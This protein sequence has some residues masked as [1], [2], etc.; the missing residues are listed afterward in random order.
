MN[1]YITTKATLNIINKKY[2]KNIL[3]ETI[4]KIPK[5]HNQFPQI[6]WNV[7]KILHSNNLIIDN[8][9]TINFINKQEFCNTFKLENSSN[10]IIN[11]KYPINSLINSLK[12]NSIDNFFYNKININSLT[13]KINKSKLR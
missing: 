1:I 6:Y 10:I 3:V 2:K 4:K 7:S 8:I 12:M 11:S 5:Q 13:T 9:E